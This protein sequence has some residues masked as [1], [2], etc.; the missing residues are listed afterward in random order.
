MAS[1]L[2]STGKNVMLNHLAG[3]AVYASIHSAVPDDTG[4]S[5]ISGGSPAYARLPVTWNTAAMGA[6][7]VTNSPITFDI[8]AGTTVI[9]VGLWSA[10]SGGDFYGFYD[11]IHQTF[12]SQGTYPLNAAAIQL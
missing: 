5:E 12:P 4:S 9:G 2:S 11:L 7:S 8:P 6:I 3:L 1:S 10:V